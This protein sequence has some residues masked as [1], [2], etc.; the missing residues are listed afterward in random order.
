MRIRLSKSIGA[1]VGIVWVLLFFQSV[2]VT[3]ADI[4]GGFLADDD[5]P[6]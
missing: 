2:Q 4:R 5:P 6:R 1:S 3:G